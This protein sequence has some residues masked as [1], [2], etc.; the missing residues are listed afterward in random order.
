MAATAAPPLLLVA[1]LGRSAIGSWVAPTPEIST[2]NWAQAGAA[3]SRPAEAVQ[4]WRR[5]DHEGWLTRG[6]QV[7]SMLLAAGLWQRACELGHLQVA[8]VR[9]FGDVGGER[10]SRAAVEKAAPQHVAAQEGPQRRATSAGGQAAPRARA[11]LV[12]A[13]PL[14]SGSSS[15]GR[16][17]RF[18]MVCV[19]QVAVR[20]GRPARRPRARSC[21]RSA[22]KRALAAPEQ[23]QHAIGV[24]VAVAD[25]A[26]A[27]ARQPRQLVAPSRCVRAARRVLLSGR[28][29][30]ARMLA[31][32]SAGH[33]LVGVD[34]EAPSGRCA[35]AE[36][37]VASAP[38][39]PGQSVGLDDP[40][41]DAAAAIS[42]C[43]RC[44]A[45]RRRSIRRRTP[46][47]AGSPSMLV[48]FVACD[49]DDRSDVGGMPSVGARPGEVAG[50]SAGGR[51]WI[52]AAHDPTAT[53]P[54]ARPPRRA[55]RPTSPSSRRGLVLAFVGSLVGALTEPVIPLL[56][57]AAARQ[58][59]P[60]RHAAAVDG[61]AGGRSACSPCAASPASSAQ[62]GL[63]WAAN[64]GVLRDARR[65]CSS[66]LLDAEPALF[67]RAAGQHP[68][69]HARLRGA[70]R[71]RRSSSTRC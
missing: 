37:A 11:D 71:R 2:R 60:A 31:A 9:P 42:R 35:S 51:A 39:K 5:F 23:P 13:R 25:P 54:L 21:T 55:S 66:A 7:G 56:H 50:L 57:A 44:S 30:T 38:P 27:E 48:R 12:A 22:E 43:R 61:A 59:L 40:G 68:H 45:S 69:Q 3:R 20:D 10:R 49:E 8:P 53:P 41:A 70:R 18:G 28:A 67:T 24:P 58:R 46:P 29:T 34:A 63:A 4:N 17:S 16:R 33:A 6:G 19:Q 65:R 62:Y 52:I 14:C 36:R 47:S 1:E 26:A 64:R 15:R 32:S